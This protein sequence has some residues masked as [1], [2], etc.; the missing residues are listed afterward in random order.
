M[1]E[2]SKENNIKIQFDTNPDDTQ[3]IY[4]EN[5]EIVESI[6]APQDIVLISKIADDVNVHVNQAIFN[7]AKIYLRRSNW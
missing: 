6:L 7:K 3:I 5:E 2:N 1:K 4:S